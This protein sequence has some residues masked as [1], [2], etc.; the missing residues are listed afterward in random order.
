MTL[1]L[2][3]RIEAE[4]ELDQSN[5]KLIYELRPLIFNPKNSKLVQKTPNDVEAGCT[6]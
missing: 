6:D 3:A 5:Q 1:K 4:V 2:Y